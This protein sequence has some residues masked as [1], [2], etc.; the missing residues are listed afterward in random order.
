MGL[1]ALCRPS[2]S[3]PPLWPG[4]HRTGL[5]WKP[6]SAP[7]GG[8]SSAGLAWIWQ[9]HGPHLVWEEQSPRKMGR[10]TEDRFHGQLTDPHLRPCRK[11]GRH[12]HQAVEPITGVSA[13]G[14]RIRG[15]QTRAWAPSR[16]ALPGGCPHTHPC[17]ASQPICP[18][19]IHTSSDSFSKS[20]C[21]PRN[22]CF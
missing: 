20:C 22:V 8:Q 16:P 1:A 14:T 15:Q 19:F 11:V 17:L 10:G 4:H 5:G 6:H 7:A 21:N 18:W 12:R 9:C 2:C 3:L 13:S